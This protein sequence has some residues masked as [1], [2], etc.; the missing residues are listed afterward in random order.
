MIR[1]VCIA[2]D[3]KLYFPY[4]N[5]LIPDLVVLGMGMKWT[6]YC[7]K[8]E[9]LVEY[10]KTLDNNDIV[11]FIDAYDVLPTKNIIHLEQKF[12]DF[13]IKNPDIKIIV[14]DE[15]KTINEFK[16]KNKRNILCQL[17]NEFLLINK[18]FIF[19]NSHIN[20]G[21]YIGYVSNILSVLSS[22]LQKHNVEDDQVELIE[23]AQK[24]P[25]HIHADT[26]QQFF[27]PGWN[28]FMQ[29]FNLDG[30]TTCSFIHANGNGLLDDFLLEHHNI[31]VGDNTK[32]KIRSISLQSLGK[33]GIYY[34]NFILSEIQHGINMSSLE[35]YREA[36]N[37]RIS[38]KYN[39]I[40]NSTKLLK[41]LFNK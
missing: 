12:R 25:H 6:G 33:K 35:K 22:I 8:Y 28:V 41:I 19:N 17:Q 32:K 1:Y 40:H 21:T 13:S 36:T 18:N 4:L 38:K 10:L 5:K 26:E 9:L 7:M 23:Y 30:N 11:C 37:T 24:N 39:A 14:G 16:E 31:N 3:S 2:T 34:T 20:S 27:R 29:Q 15:Q